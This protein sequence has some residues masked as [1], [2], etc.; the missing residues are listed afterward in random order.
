MCNIVDM[1]EY[2]IMCV[3]DHDMYVIRGRD[4]VQDEMSAVLHA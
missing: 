2:H 3:Q 1:Y 4:V